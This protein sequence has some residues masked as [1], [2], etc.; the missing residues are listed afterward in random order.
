MKQVFIVNNGSK[1][2]QYGIGT[3]I[4]QLLLCL[5]ACVSMQV[6]VVVLDSVESEL[7]EKWIDGVRYLLFPTVRIHK[8]EKS[9]KR[10]ARNIAYALFPYVNPA[11]EII[12]HFNYSYHAGLAE[13]LK[14]RF[15]GCYTILTLHYLPWCFDLAGNMCHFQ[16]ILVKKEEERDEFEQQIYEEYLSDRCF[17]NK[18][19]KLI[20]LCNATRVFLHET[21]QVPAENMALIYNGLSDTRQ[22]LAEAD[23]KEIKRGLGFGENESV[24]LFVGRINRLKG[25][26]W[27]IDAF[28][29]MLEEFP[30]ARLVIAGDGD[31]TE[32][33]PLCDGL[34]GKV[35][36]TGKLD[37][38]QLSVFYRIADLGVLPSLQEQCSYVGIE[39]MMQG[40]PLVG[41]NAMGVSEMVEKE[42]Q[43][44]L[45][46]SE[47]DVLLSTS[48][49]SE[50]ML[51][52][53]ANREKL[54]RLSRLRFEQCYSLDA[55]RQEMEQLYD[56]C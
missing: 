23:K 30:E 19:D 8:D 49:L 6:T 18:V 9:R 3:Y 1:A 56:Y 35:V 22:V 5:E 55:M 27:L 24:I 7:T 52:A 53:M 45:F 46:V 25:I 39:M 32:C 38:R 50:L 43:V 54:G 13:E 15:S 41:T 21:Y 26:H 28:R 34:E 36:F 4:E 42:Y 47:N 48:R 16:S 2:A 31:I 20:C 37:K 11:A 14:S 12:F 17:Y 33:L 51:D 40:L 10:Y 44:P 29:K